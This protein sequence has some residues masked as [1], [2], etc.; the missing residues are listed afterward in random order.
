MS[1][2]KLYKIYLSIHKNFIKIS[3]EY[4][5]IDNR[6]NVPYE[7]YFIEWMHGM[8]VRFRSLTNEITINEKTYLTPKEFKNIME[9]EFKNED[10]QV[11][12]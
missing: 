2:N 7:E 11:I 5:L 4:F 3:K 10:I 6:F 8:G 12:Y 1:K 9:K